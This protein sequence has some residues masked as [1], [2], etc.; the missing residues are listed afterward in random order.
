[1]YQSHK[2]YNLYYLMPSH[3]D[4]GE[5]RCVAIHSRY[6]VGAQT[7]S[8][9]PGTSSVQSNPNYPH[10][11]LCRTSCHPLGCFIPV[12]IWWITGHGYVTTHFNP[13]FLLCIDK[14]QHTW[15]II[16]ILGSQPSTLWSAQSVGSDLAWSVSE[17]HF[18]L[19]VSHIKLF[20]QENY[21]NIYR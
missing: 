9:K 7:R 13:I 1:M 8:E 14:V 16:N 11:E 18:W 15:E 6:L 20:L 19:W 12:V 17:K 5:Y 4:H 3:V 2:W 21:S 10:H